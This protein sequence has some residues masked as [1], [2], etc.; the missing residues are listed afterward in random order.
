MKAV[1]G[2]VAPEYPVFINIALENRE[3]LVSMLQMTGQWGDDPNLP[4]L[5]R[6]FKVVAQEATRRGIVY[7]D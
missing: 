3:E 2:G 1:A 7:E 6:L 5:E 4:N